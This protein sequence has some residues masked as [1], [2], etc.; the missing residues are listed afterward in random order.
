MSRFLIPI[1]GLITNLTADDSSDVR[2]SRH[3]RSQWHSGGPFVVPN[4]S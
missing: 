3:W 4:V 1:V 2:A